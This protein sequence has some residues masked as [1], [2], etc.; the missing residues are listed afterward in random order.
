MPLFTTLLHRISFDLM[1]ML[2]PFISRE[3]SLC[4]SPSSQNG[5]WTGLIG[6]LAKREG[7]GADMVLTSLKVRVTQ[8]YVIVTHLLGQGDSASK[9]GGQSFM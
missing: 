4:S 3:C 6:E 8:P 5:K 1:Y 2:L 7:E 9:S